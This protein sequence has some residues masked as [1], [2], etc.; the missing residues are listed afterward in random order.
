MERR[1][2]DQA[3]MSGGAGS[4]GGPQKSGRINMAKRTAGRLLPVQADPSVPQVDVA[5]RA[6]DGSGGEGGGAGEGAGGESG[7]RSGS[8][9]EDSEPDPQAQQSELCG[10]QATAVERSGD[11][12]FRVGVRVEVLWKGKWNG[13]FAGF[14]TGFNAE[15]GE[16]RV[17]YD[18]GKHDWHGAEQMR[19]APADQGKMDAAEL[20]SY[21]KRGGYAFVNRT[22]AAKADAAVARGTARTCLADALWSA[23]RTAGVPVTV[24][25][26]RSSMP[27]KFQDPCVLD[28]MRFAASVGARLELVQKLSGSAFNLFCERVGSYLVRL[29]M[30][31]E[32][33]RFFHFVA[34]DAST[35]RLLD[36]DLPRVPV[37]EDADRVD[38]SA[39]ISTIVAIYNHV[40]EV[41]VRDVWVVTIC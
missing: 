11:R 39:A 9:P 29:E 24:R 41:R 38:R 5:D 34:Y 12:M 30:R 10:V 32:D 35:G 16:Y 3:G 25:D 33:Q 6:Q 36:N 7:A 8:D 28:A 22:D 31:S 17:E 1:K 40:T 2:R 15:R 14:V 27:A 20:R 37:I 4:T 21:H 19:S 26:V 13:W 18:D 23:L